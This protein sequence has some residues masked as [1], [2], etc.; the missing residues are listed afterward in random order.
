MLTMQT[1]G[2]LVLYAL[3]IQ[4]TPTSQA[5]WST[6]TSGNPGAYATM[7]TDGNLV[8]YKPDF[9]YTTPGTSANA[10]W[11]SATPNNPAAVAKIQDDCNFV[12]YNTTGTPVWNTHTYN[13]NP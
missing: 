4:N 10:L 2:N 1:D 11:S 13:P 7:Q 9:A 12:I 3:N 6:N 5:L 8:V